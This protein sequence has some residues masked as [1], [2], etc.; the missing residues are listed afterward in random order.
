MLEL[1]CTYQ[2]H[3]PDWVYSLAPPNRAQRRPAPQRIRCSVQLR[4]RFI[5]LAFFFCLFAPVAAAQENTEEPPAL[6]LEVVYTVD[7]VANLQGGL[8]RGTRMPHNIDILVNLDLEQ[9]LGW[10]HTT[11]FVYGLGNYGGMPTELVGDLQVTSN[12]EADTAWRVYE[13]FLELCL[14]AERVSLLAGLYNT[15]SEFDELESAGVFLNASFGVGPDLSASRD[16]GPSIFP[17]TSLAARV[18]AFP[19][20]WW[21]VQAAGMDGVPGL[22]GHPYAGPFHFDANDGVFLIAETGLLAELK[23]STASRQALP[24]PH[25]YFLTAF[26]Y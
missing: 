14:W 21:Y 15:N 20:P 5:L 3:T 6:V 19:R 11:G 13:A 26:A 4:I 8:K 9:S 24:S 18:R 1:D 2:I 12:I 22:P 17:V 7:G 23:K 10:N 25:K 16:Q